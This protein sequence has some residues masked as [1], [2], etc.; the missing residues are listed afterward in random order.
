MDSTDRVPS[1]LEIQ[2]KPGKKLSDKVGEHFFYFSK[3]S[4]NF[5]LNADCHKL[6]NVMIFI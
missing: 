5:F 6:K 1:D 2:R 4:G 3:K